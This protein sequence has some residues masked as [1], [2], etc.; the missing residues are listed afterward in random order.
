MLC[1][2]RRNALCALKDEDVKLE[3]IMKDGMARLTW[4]GE[5]GGFALWRG[6]RKRKRRVG[7]DCGY[8]KGEWVLRV[9]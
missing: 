7:H 2:S 8:G 1:S 4:A 9:C 5:E 6:V 3:G